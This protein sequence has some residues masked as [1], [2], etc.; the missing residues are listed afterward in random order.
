MGAACQAPLSRGFSR[1]EYWRGLPFPS[2]GDLPAPG[3]KSGS[4]TLEGRF[5]TIWATSLSLNTWGRSVT[6]QTSLTLIHIKK[7]HVLSCARMHIHLYAKKERGREKGNLVK[8]PSPQLVG[9]GECDPRQSSETTLVRCKIHRSEESL[10]S[11]WLGLSAFTA[12]AWVQSLVWELWS[13]KQLGPKI[14]T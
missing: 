3:I 11:W 8:S 2:L 5:F 14:T 9:G 10:V 1:Q 13:S 6:C 12:V 7:H 4:P